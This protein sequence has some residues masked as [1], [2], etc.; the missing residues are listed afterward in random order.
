MKYIQEKIAEINPYDSRLVTAAKIWYYWNV[1]AACTAEWTYRI[2]DLPL[3]WDEFQERLGVELDR[4]LM[5]SVSTEEGS[6]KDRFKEY[7]TWEDLEQCLD[8]SLYQD[9]REYAESYQ[10]YE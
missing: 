6:R 7:I 9:I 10:Y 3:V 1:E 8:P 4:E 2:E 5:L